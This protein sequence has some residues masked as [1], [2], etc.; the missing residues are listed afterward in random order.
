M[1]S[2]FANTSN[3]WD[4]PARRWINKHASPVNA[5]LIIEASPRLAFIDGDTNVVETGFAFSACTW[6][7]NQQWADAAATDAKTQYGEHDCDFQYAF[8][9]LSVHDHFLG[10]QES[11]CLLLNH[12]RI[13]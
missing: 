12:C 8:D 9:W 2:L 11:L 3:A 4:A 7:N 5:N 13:P 6:Q 1:H 10:P